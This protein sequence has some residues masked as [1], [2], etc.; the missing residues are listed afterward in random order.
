MECNARNERDRGWFKSSY[1]YDKDCVEVR[2]TADGAE[3]RD[4][5]DP[6]GPR[7][8]FT[9]GEWAAFIAALR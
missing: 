2:F 3:M 7:L 8:Y 6:D 5:K 9:Y 1:S 4:S